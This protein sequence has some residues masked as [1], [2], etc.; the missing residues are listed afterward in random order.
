MSPIPQKAFN[1]HPLY[2]EPSTDA[3]LIRESGFSRT[4]DFGPL[5]KS[6]DAR[7]LI[8]RVN[9]SAGWKFST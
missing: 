2:V 1:S 8:R 9:E 6:E 5:K 4:S 7:T 3:E